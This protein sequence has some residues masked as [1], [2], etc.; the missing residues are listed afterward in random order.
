MIP[1]GGG[2]I[3]RCSIAATSTATRWWSSFIQ[4]DI[5]YTVE[6]ID[7]L[8]T[9]EVRDLLSALRAIEG[10]DPVGLLRISALPKFNV[11]GKAIRAEVAAQE[12]K[13]DLEAA[14]DKVAGGSEVMT[15]LAEARHDVQR[16]QSKALA[17]C[18]LAQR[19]FG[20]ASTAETEGFTEFVQSWSRKPQQVSGDGT[21][22]EF[23]EY[24]DY[25]I[26]GG[27]R[28][29][30][31]E[32]DDAGTPATLQMEIGNV[33]KAERSEDAVRLLTVHAAKGLEFPVVF[34]LR[35]G[36]PSLPSSYHEELV[37]FPAELRDPDTT[38]EG[39]PKDLHVQE[40][41]RLFY[42][43]LTRAEDELI[44]SGKKATGKVTQVPS[45]YLRELVTAGTKSLK[46]C[47]E[48]G[49]IPSG[50]V[51]PAIHAGAQPMS[52]IAEWM[53]LP[54]LPQTTAPNV[55]CQRHRPL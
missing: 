26:E 30:D 25:F 2:A 54:P 24:L 29:V 4:R 46:G 45:G 27:G 5:P 41:R 34:V 31:Q 32:A 16:L 7:L 55:E 52:R 3:S 9:A 40:E 19:H 35:V 36:S 48:Y 18:G 10:G 39:Q 15:V 37:E 21:L 49:L 33:P 23:L 22:R 17:A 8:E 1:A 28:I 50:E 6:G 44:L 20:I 13:A 51:I 43:A 14:L 47:V 53:E 38:P 11:D 12:K 42:V